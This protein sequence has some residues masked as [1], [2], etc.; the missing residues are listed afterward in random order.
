MA[1]DNFLEV[2]QEDLT[3]RADEVAQKLA[4][5]LDLS[6]S[7]A[8]NVASYLRSQRVEQTGNAEKTEEIYLEDL[9]WP[10][11]LKRACR[12]LCESAAAEFDY[13]L[14]RP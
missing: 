7:E 11:D 4:E 13:R 1:A 9:D 6:P 14:S 3:P 12:E 2:R 8:A 5:L 10:E